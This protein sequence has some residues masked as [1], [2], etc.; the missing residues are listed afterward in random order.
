MNKVI[1]TLALAISLMVSPAIAWDLEEMNRQV[2]KTNFIVN[3]GCSGTLIDATKKQVLTAEHCISQSIITVEE[4]EVQPD[5]TVKKVRRS[6][7]R[8]LEVTQNVYD[9]DGNIIGKNVHRAKIIGSKAKVDLALLALEGNEVLFGKAAEVLP[10]DQ[11]ITRGEVIWIV[12][13]PFGHANT[14]TRGIVSHIKRELPGASGY[15][16]DVL[17][18][19]IDAGAAPGNSGGAIYNDKGQLIGVLVRGYNG[20]GHLAFAVSIE[21]IREF[22]KNPSG[23]SYSNAY[24]GGHAM[25]TSTMDI[26]QSRNQAR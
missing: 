15:N 7:K 6:Y 8:P 25:S 1:T 5:G 2:D 3:E 21:D 19:Q 4:D 13:N 22:I 11:K 12:G 17:F 23:M 20:F 24:F 18:T 14:V 10:K 16:N 26:P 9:L